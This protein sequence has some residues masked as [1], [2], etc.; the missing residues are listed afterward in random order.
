MLDRPLS[1]KQNVRFQVRM[2][3]TISQP[4]GEGGF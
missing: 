2:Q 4:V 3:P 1:I